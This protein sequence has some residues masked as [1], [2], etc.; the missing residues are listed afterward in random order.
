MATNLDIDPDIQFPGIAIPC[1]YITESQINNF[2]EI[3]CSSFL[4]VNCR[5]F[6]ANFDKLS[7]MVLQLKNNASV[8]AVTETWTSKL[9]E[10]LFTL[11]GYKFVC[12]SRC[13]RTGGGVGLFIDQ[14]LTFKVRT[15]LRP[16]DNIECIF[17]EITQ[18]NKAN[19]LIGAI[20][21]PPNNDIR[22][23]NAEFSLLLDKLDSVAKNKT[24]MLAGDYNLDL[25]MSDT[26]S[27]VGN[28]VSTLTAYSFVPTVTLPTR[29]TAN[30][31]SLLDNI[32]IKSFVGQAS[33]AV[34]YSDISDHLPVLLKLSKKLNTKELPA[35][36]KKRQFTEKNITKFISLLQSERWDNVTEAV[37]A[38]LVPGL[39][40]NIFITRF[41][42][43]FKICFPIRSCRT[44]NK[45]C[46]RTS[47][48]TKGL[49]KCCNKKSKLYKKSITNPTEETKTKYVTYRNKL[50]TILQKAKKTF[51]E[52][53]LKS[54]NGNLKKTWGLLRE[55]INKDNNSVDACTIFNLNNTTVVRNPQDIADC[56]N[57]YFANV[58][59]KLSG[60]IPR[61]ASNAY[62][63]YLQG[64]YPDSL[65]LTP[66]T[67]AEILNI[68]ANL[69]DKD[70]AGSDE[71]PLSLLKKCAQPLTLILSMLVNNA[72]CT[73][74]FPDELKI[75][76]VCPIFKTGQPDVFSNYRPI[77]LLSSFSKVFEKAIHLRLENYITS[78]NIL[79][80]NQYGFRTGH[81][82]YMALLD[83][84]DK[85]TKN[86]EN[87]LVTVGVFIDLQKA[88]DSLE[89]SILLGKLCH[90]GVR[91]IPLQLFTS[92]LENR[93]QYVF[94][95]NASSAY[96]GIDFGV[97]QGSILGPILFLLY[98]NDI[99]CSSPV[100]HF[101]L[102]A[103]DTSILLSG[104]NCND[105]MNVL[106]PELS[107]LSLWFEINKLSLNV[108]KTNYMLYG[109]KRKFIPHSSFDIVINN[110]SVTRATEVKFLGIMVD[111]E[112]KWK[113]HT[114]YIATKIS[115]NIGILNRLRFV[116]NC[117]TLKTLYM[118]LV[119]PYISYGI[120]VWGTA[121][122]VTID[123]VEKLQKR[124]IRLI[125][126]SRYRDHTSPLFAS[127]K[128]LKV[129]DLYTKEIAVFMYKAMYRLLPQSCSSYVVRASDRLHSLRVIDDFEQIRVKT[130]A[131]QNFI[132]WAG[133]KLWK[134][135]PKII[136]QSN[137]LSIFKNK[138]MEHLIS[139]YHTQHST[140]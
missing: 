80:N 86:L 7:T 88:F 62:T 118:T 131:R 105:V 85:I 38:N 21:R 70:S 81:S 126:F 32:F 99:V 130:T 114:S 132:S 119:H 90:Y 50:S 52:S 31:S 113:A 95:N 29:L 79:V 48:I 89:H 65:M 129:R 109:N 63:Q 91:G 98:I 66:C 68:I 117:A 122:Q 47:W 11:P 116:L 57:E 37:T 110:M 120:I 16:S 125:S 128:L 33:T 30:N 135:T 124:A 73:G 41:L 83:L 53:E 112:L 18:F 127:N 56:F 137:S 42:E 2:L 49:I 134:A 77:S 74:H 36:V 82:T 94:Y 35:Q 64:S 60:N 1:K 24:I 59:A 140:C 136:R 139:Q 104:K 87:N 5:S 93:K 84:Q 3:P 107:K 28:F 102:F 23:F 13:D 108:Q 46:P 8:I 20:Y 61:H 12:N 72:F 39:G 123:K 97:P 111:D 40:Y 92:Y 27:Y 45:N 44:K 54:Y 10:S 26:N 9:T 43:L 14:Q 4:H 15:D 34:I 51:Y 25:M 106:N 115:K 103:D 55:L 6:N 76:K 71:I 121:N 67:P 19:I 22:A 75:A 133:P 96:K 69:N 78:R 101:L 138:M 17:V 100:L 58:G